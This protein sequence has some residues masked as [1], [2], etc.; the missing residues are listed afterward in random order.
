MFV[1]S[2]SVKRIFFVDFLKIEK[3]K[4]NKLMEMVSY[5]IYMLMGGS[6]L[7]EIG[8]MLI[9]KSYANERF[10]FLMGVTVMRGFLL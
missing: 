6:Y 2:K 10:R 7:E 1:L 5:A 3:N 4:K 8:E 9:G